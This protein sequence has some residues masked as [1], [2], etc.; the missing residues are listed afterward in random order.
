MIEYELCNPREHIAAGKKFR[1]SE[2]HNHVLGTSNGITSKIPTSNSSLTTLNTLEIKTTPIEYDSSWLPDLIVD[3][4]W[5]SK[6]R[7]EFSKQY[8]KSIEK[9]LDV[10]YAKGKKIFPPKSLIFNAFNVT[11]LDQVKVVI[12]GQDPYHDDGQVVKNTCLRKKLQN[13]LI[14][15]GVVKT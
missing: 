7:A 9:F 10:Q 3:K 4:N 2:E 14:L 8:F 6:L 5:R 1:I 11:P 15:Q 12:L 13:A